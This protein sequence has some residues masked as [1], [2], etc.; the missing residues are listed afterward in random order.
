MIARRQRV[1]G[2]PNYSHFIVIPANTM[3][4][5]EATVAVGRLMLVDPTGRID[6][7]D[8]AQIIETVID[9][10]AYKISQG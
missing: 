4:G 3:I 9:P 5:E 7:K 6:E 10:W 1:M 8:L 2:G